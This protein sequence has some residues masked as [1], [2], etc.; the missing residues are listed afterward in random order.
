ML[1]DLGKLPP[2]G[3]TYDVVVIGAG[4]AGMSAALFAAIEGKKALLVERTEYVGGTTALSAATTWIPGTRH[5]AT[6]SEG[7]TLEAAAKF[8]TNAIGDR[9]P[10]ELRRVLLETGPEAV[11]HVEANS[12][13]KYRAYPL[14]PDYLTELE[15]S[16]LKGRALEPIP[17]DG[18]KLGDLL[19]LIRP[20]IPEFTV[21]GGMAVDRNDIFHLLR[22]T[23][24]F[25][26][27][28]YCTKIILRHMQD[29]LTHTRGTRL[30]MG[31]A[32][33][34]RLLYSLNERK[35]PIAMKTSLEQI[36][37]NASGVHAVTLVQGG[38]HRTVKVTGGVILA[39]GGFTLNPKLRKQMLPGVD[40]AWC[41]AAPGHTGEA[42]ELALSMGAHYGTGA[43]TNSFWAPVSLRKRRDGSTAVFPHFVMDRA[44]PGFITVNKKGERFLNESTSY[45]LFGLAMQETNKKTEAIP[46]YL[47]C[48]ARALKKYGIGM[49]RPGGHGLGPFLK[50]GYL[51]KGNTLEELAAKLKI[52]AGGLKDSVTRIN[53][54]AQTGIDPDFGRGTTAY[55]RNNGDATWTGK[56]PSIGPLTEGPYYAVRLYPG[57][58]GAATGLVTD[59]S[60]Q[61]L[62]AANQPI[63]GLYAIGND[64]HSAMGGVYTAPGITVGPG[65]VFGYIAARHAVSRKASEKVAA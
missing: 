5:A 41:P 26:S 59:V 46:A 15:G 12:E 50:D 33:I 3:E 52:D 4:G 13:V 34:G 45:H 36:H 16:T 56:N 30:V 65:L 19:S 8:L 39:T 9:T 29:R 24:T 32:L 2:D 40:L 37:A 6:V 54:Y 20:P 44:K 53:A 18:R 11:D 63:A 28:W 27:F 14:H 49:V 58:I 62:D 10:A 22:V 60:A 1:L 57:D 38:V 17:Y 51:T 25:K 55:Q 21:L 48:D 7:D 23:D 42:H 35:V 31:N 47:V 43:L 61:V 64:M